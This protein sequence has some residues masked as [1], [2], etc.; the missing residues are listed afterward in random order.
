M[1]RAATAS[2]GRHLTLALTVTAL[3]LFLPASARAQAGLP[4]ALA[5]AVAQ[6]D[7]MAIDEL[8]KDGLGSA[9]V[10]VV[11][12]DRLAWTKSYGYADMEAQTPATQD[13]V[14]RIGSITKPF[15]ALML[16]QLVE[17]GTLRPSEPIDKY[18]PDM[19]TVVGRAADAPPITFVQ[20][21]TMT[22]GLGREPDDLPTYL[23]GPVSRWED[24]MR[25]AL[26][27]VTYRFEPDTH[28]HYSNIGYAI[29]GAALGRAAGRP[30]VEYMQDEIF[31]PLGMTRTA[32]EPNAEIE[33]HLST[34]YAVR[35]GHVDAETPAR[36]HAGRGYKVPNGAMY[37]TVGDLAT[38]LIFQLGLGPREVLTPETLE[39]NFS[40]VNSANGDLTSGYGVGFQARRLGDLVAYGHGG[41]VAGYQAAAWVD[42]VSRTGVVVLRNVG[43]GAFRVGELCLRAL[44]TVAAAV[45]TATP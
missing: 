45:P 42:R 5:D 9:T 18:F 14:Y 7:R 11:V 41:S 6:I 38:F 13:T 17:R 25:S 4:S 31:R 33:A 44:E 30:Y 23:K 26:S 37:T 28:Y 27:Q 34:G 32:F 36:E 24:V 3:A 2:A 8:A 15:T 21:A 16:L 10:G 35:D 43:G 22:S 40:R 12:G 20:L 29:L 1:R 39:D 19:A